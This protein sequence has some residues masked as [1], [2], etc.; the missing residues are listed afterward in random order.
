MQIGMS[1]P[2]RSSM[3]GTHTRY[4]SSLTSLVGYF[5]N[6]ALIV[7]LLTTSGPRTGLSCS[8]VSVLFLL[9]LSV[10]PSHIFQVSVE[11]FGVKAL[12]E[13]LFKAGPVSGVSWSL[14]R[15][16]PPLDR[17]WFRRT[18]PGRQY[19]TGEKR[20]PNCCFPQAS[21]YVSPKILN[22]NSL[23]VAYVLTRAVLGSLECCKGFSPP[24][25]ADMGVQRYC[26]LSRRN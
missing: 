18:M 24:R 23:T 25:I 5:S 17:P 11:G 10:A 13:H 15:L 7:G 20:F 2:A 6:V 8:K 16:N 19:R 4:T 9:V 21:G 14:H 3:I 12:S 26:T 1:P 22:L